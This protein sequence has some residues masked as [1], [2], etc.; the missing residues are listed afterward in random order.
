[1]IYELWNLLLFYSDSKS[2][3]ILNL[4]HSGVL[5]FSNYSLRDFFKLIEQEQKA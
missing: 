5:S 4:V 2:E 1:M 3:L